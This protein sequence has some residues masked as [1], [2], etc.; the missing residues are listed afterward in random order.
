MWTTHPW[1]PEARWN[2]G[3]NHRQEARTTFQVVEGI[4]DDILSV[5]CAVDAGARVVFDAAGSY[6]EW[7]NGSRADFI[8]NGRQLLMPYTCCRKH[9]KRA[10]IA[11]LRDEEDYADDPEA[12]AWRSLPERR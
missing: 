5:N 1:L 12:R 3:G 2:L 6:I 11:A 9:K 7:E 4:T 8:R 10:T